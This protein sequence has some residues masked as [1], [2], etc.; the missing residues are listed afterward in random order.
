MA[1][2]IDG[3]NE[4][5]AEAVMTTEG[6]LLIMAGAGSGK[7]RVLTH[8][9]AHL[10]DDLDV[11]P[12][13]ILAITFTNKAAREMKERIAQL[14]GDET[15]DAVWVST[16][17]ALAVRI[18]RR[19]IDRLGYKKDFTILD[20]GTQRTLVKRIMRDQNIDIEKFQP[21][22]VQA[23]ISNAKN[24][25]EKPA[26]YAQH[27]DSVFDKLVA[28]VYTEYQNQ[29][30]LSQSV[31]FD[32]LIMLTIELL[33]A[34]PDV[35]AYYQEKFSYIH[36]DEYQDTNDA[37]YRLVSLLAEK[38]QNLAVVGDSDQ[39]IYGWRGANIQI[40]LNFE[41]DYPKAKTV[42]LE[43]NYR[44]T[45]TILDAANAVIANNS[46]RIAK[47]LW[48]AN[49]DGEKITYYRGQSERDEALFVVGQ[50]SQ[51][52]AEN[53]RKYA[54]FA[55][56]YRTNAQSR[57]I[58][59]A[60]VKANIPYTMVGGSKFYE[61][62]EIRDVLAYLSLATNPAD[63]E[64]FLRVVNE[65]K[66]G[67][68]TTSLEKLRAFAGQNNWTLL[69]AAQNANL[70]NGLQSRAVNKLAEFAD[71][72]NNFQQQET[73]ELS[74]TE[75]TNQILDRSGYRQILL[76]Q[77]TPENQ[78]RLENLDEFL[79]VTQQFDDHYQPNDESVSKYVDFMGELALVSDLD[80]LDEETT[81]TVTLM[82]LHAAK[83][84]EFPVVFLVGLEEGIF[85]LARANED[86]SQMQEERRL[87]YVGITRAKENLYV[88][89]AYS[90][91]LYGRTSSNPP[92]RFIQ[93]IDQSL[94]TQPYGQ[95]LS[96]RDNLDEALPF[97][98]RTQQAMST[99][100]KGRTVQH[101]TSSASPNVQSTGAE[102]A[103]WQI[104]DAV[105]HKKWGVG[106][107]VKTSGAGEDQEL[108]IAFPN[109]G[110]K[111]LL[112]AFAPIQRV[113]SE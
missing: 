41:K 69:E 62:K 42:M 11:R 98:R 93:E 113:E 50:I 88:T 87:A 36:V 5:Q 12:W 72:I 47:N 84:L 37:Q 6:P 54:D 53:R 102:K 49:G 111:R 82:T 35:L 38:H 33:E 29:L 55:I 28:Q 77:P 110:I 30:A 80:N 58:E 48:T 86:E 70:I 73:F 56:L 107:I 64:S 46:E 95:T 1:T 14:V 104:G 20:G 18:L 105:S 43:Q 26:E 108:D 9:V 19:D 27:A 100:F 7:T 109:Q 51:A 61:R 34:A 68:G 90:R 71:L 106:R 45:Q 59:E 85:P 63:N 13:R 4:R 10:I 75:L 99:T 78:N 101:S 112:A 79:T 2:L 97:A 89:N 60:L 65:P 17:H 44:S 91:Q 22:S 52:Y 21:R 67:L 3:M 76:D 8:R 66:R 103:S 24:A 81:D 31:D 15:A 25:M 23:A 39:S 32:D 74:V 94:I 16:F 96:S 83:G 40:I 92:S 57:G